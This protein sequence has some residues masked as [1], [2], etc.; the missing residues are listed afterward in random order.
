MKIRISRLLMAFAVLGVAL[1][2]GAL[3]VA[4]VGVGTWTMYISKR[5]DPGRAFESQADAAAYYIQDL[6]RTVDPTKNSRCWRMFWNNSSSGPSTDIRWANGVMTVGCAWPSPDSGTAADFTLGITTAITCTLTSADERCT[7]SLLPSNTKNAGPPCDAACV[8]DTYSP[9]PAGAVSVGNSINVGTGNK[10]Q[11]ETDFTVPGSPWLSFSRYYNSQP[12][13]AIGP[14]MGIRWRHSFDYALQ[15]GSG[16]VLSFLR[17]DGSVRVFN[18][19]AGADA[20]TQGYVDY[21]LDSNGGVVGY[22]LHDEN[23]RTE[24]YT[25]SGAISRIDF[26]EGGFVAFNYAP[27][28][29]ARPTHVTDHFGRSLAFTYDNLSRVTK[30]TTPS[31]AAYTYTY[32]NFDRLTRRTAPGS[33]TRIYGYDAS[34]ANPT[35]AQRG[36]LTSISDETN[37]IVGRYYYD[38]KSRAI[39]TEGAAGTEKYLLSYTT[40]AT[41]VTHPLG[42]TTSMTVATVLGTPRVVSTSTSCT[43]SGCVAPGPTTATFDA[44]G[45]LVAS[46][47]PNGSKS[48]MSYNLERNLLERQADGLPAGAECASALAGD[49]LA[50]PATLTTIQWHPD[51]RLPT[52]VASPKLRETF[53]YDLQGRLTGHTSQATSDATGAAGMFAQSVGTPRSR[54]FTYNAF[55]QLTSQTGPRSDVSDITTYNYGAAGVLTSV[56][57]PGGLVTTYSGHDAEGRPGRVTLPS[58]ISVDLTYDARGRVT[59]VNKAGLTTSFTYFPNGNV[60]SK[61]TPDGEVLTYTYDGASRVTKVTDQRGNSRNFT[62]NLAGGVLTEQTKSTA[63]ATV[64]STTRVF[65]A[66]NRVT[67]ISGAHHINPQPAAY[68]P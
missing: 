43:G 45:N 40:G 65:D 25:K 1:L 38:T 11:V 19:L 30:V 12:A 17:P 18:S 4:Q 44:N 46:T 36:L 37:T 20:D 48:C 3:V 61:T 58:G 24:L 31:G 51:F 10:F 27:G 60:A 34:G 42:A 64:L 23:G 8:P 62:Y 56:T 29:T 49:S 32:D 35:T 47:G 15:V 6:G 2:M 9:K 21:V 33:Q 7:Q 66:L 50:L 67:Q 22:T 14:S 41:P 13:R 59:S 57:N 63:G 54:V 52:A 39:R 5:G 16:N 28:T 53:S 68:A 26:R 55:G